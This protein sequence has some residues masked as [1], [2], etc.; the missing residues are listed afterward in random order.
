MRN[1]PGGFR[2]IERS[3][4]GVRGFQSHR[5]H[6]IRS[7]PLSAWRLSAPHSGQTRSSQI[8]LRRRSTTVRTAVR[9]SHTH[10]PANLLEQ[11]RCDRFQSKHLERNHSSRTPHAMRLSSST[12]Q[13]TLN[14]INNLLCKNVLRI[15]YLFSFPAYPIPSRL[16][17][18]K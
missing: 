3:P 6:Q 5:P 17:L 10:T 18:L 14:S 15:M 13:L 2:L 1:S 9:A 12:P 7:E 8:I 4:S 16:S 11:I